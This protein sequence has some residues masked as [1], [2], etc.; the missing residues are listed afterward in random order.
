LEISQQLDFSNTQGGWYLKDTTKN[1][2]PREVPLWGD[3]LEAVEK[4]LAQRE[5]MSKKPDWNPDE[6]FANLL[7]LGEGGKL[8]TRRQDT[9]MWHALG[10]GMRGHLARHITGHILAKNDISTETAKKILGH[11][12]D[13]YMHYY[14]V[15]SSEMAS[16]ELKSKYRPG[17]RKRK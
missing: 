16:K 4:R 8:V 7:F 11:Q 1:G 9:P 2:K 10:T 5:E 17:E 12:S 3:F 15:V 13:A 6:K 14:R